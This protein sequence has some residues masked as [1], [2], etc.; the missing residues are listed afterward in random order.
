[1]ENENVDKVKEI[2]LLQE[3]ISGMQVTVNYKLSKGEILKAGLVAG[4]AALLGMAAYTE[5]KGWFWKRKAKKEIKKM[6][7]E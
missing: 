2:N 4:G 6:F 5:I 3:A 7:T 1:M